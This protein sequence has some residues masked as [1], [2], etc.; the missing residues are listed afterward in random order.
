MSICL[1]CDSSIVATCPSIP[2]ACFAFRLCFIRFVLLFKVV[3]LV[4]KN[5]LR[6]RVGLPQT[7]S[8]PQ[9]NFIAGRPNAALLFMVLSDF[10]CGALLFMVILAI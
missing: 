5:R 10:R 3:F 1:V 9:S 2:A 4:N 7:S 6:S 8:I